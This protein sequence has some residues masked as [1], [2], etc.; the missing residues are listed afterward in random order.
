MRLAGPSAASVP[1]DGLRARHGQQVRW[2]ANFV[3]AIGAAYFAE[4]TLRFY[5][6]THRLIGV[7]FLA[8]QTWIVLAYLLRRPARTTSRR[9]GDW[10]LAFTGT[11]GGVLFRPVGAHPQ[12]GVAVGLTLQLFGLSLCVVALLSLGR[13]FGFAAA[14]RGLVTRGPYG[15][16][17]HPIYTSYFVMGLG[18]LLQSLSVWNLLVLTF[19]TASNVGRSVAEERLLATSLPYAAYRR[20]VRWRLA[21]GL[22]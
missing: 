5:L 20:R 4:A 11:F 13:S 15:M 10:L 19:I 18:Y 17:R 7:A 8:E 3:G 16:V 6:H 1:I 14:D 21:P 9:L 12:W 2:S 22:W